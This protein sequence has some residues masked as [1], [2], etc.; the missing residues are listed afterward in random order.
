MV[1][2]DLDPVKTRER[3]EYWFSDVGAG[4]V[5]PLVTPTGVKPFTVRGLLDP[6]GLA[7]TLG[8]RW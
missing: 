1:A 3:V 7:R 6:Q 8:A 4:S 5:L 2:G